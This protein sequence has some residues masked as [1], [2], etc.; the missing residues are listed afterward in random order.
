[1]VREKW[2]LEIATLGHD[3]GYCESALRQALRTCTTTLLVLPMLS[4]D[5]CSFAAAGKAPTQSTLAAATMLVHVQ[6]QNTPTNLRAIGSSASPAYPLKASAN[7]RYLVDQNDV[8][9]LMVGVPASLDRQ[10][11]SNGGRVFHGESPT[12]RHQCVVDQSL[13]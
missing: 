8:P 11:V 3:G 10:L 9:F 4:N 13:V 5:Y 7:N 1:M 2:K 6:V 12:L